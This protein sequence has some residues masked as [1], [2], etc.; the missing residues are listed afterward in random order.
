MPVD[1]DDTG[2]VADKEAV[3]DTHFL[4]YTDPSLRLGYQREKKG[5]GS[6][7]NCSLYQHVVRPPLIRLGPPKA[8][9]P[10]RLGFPVEGAWAYFLEPWSHLRRELKSPHWTGTPRGK[11]LP[12][13]QETE[14]YHGGEGP[15][16]PP[17]Y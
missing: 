3:W 6:P 9:S 4:R 10:T 17:L 7:I 8:A 2:V 5:M 13:P 14:K 12:L 11:E 16:P 15:E 1:D